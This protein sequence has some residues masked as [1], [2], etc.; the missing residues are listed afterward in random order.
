M[1]PAKFDYHCPA[2]IE[3]VLDLLAKYGDDAKLLAGGQSLVPMMNMRLARPSIIIDINRVAGLDYIKE[4]EDRGLSIGAMTRQRA[5]EC[6]SLVSSLNPLISQV[7]PNIG[8]FQIRNRGTL[9]GSVSHADPSAEIP[10][11]CRILDA[12]FTL[13]SKNGC[14]TVGS[15]EFFITYFT[16][17]LQSTEI[18]TEIRLPQLRSDLGWG[19]E[20]MARRHGDFAMVG[21]IALIEPASNGVCKSV[22]LTMFGV[23][24]VPLKMTEVEDSLS[25]VCLDHKILECVSRQISATLDP[26]SDIHAS[27]EYRK[28]VGGV[29]ARRA[30]MAASRLAFGSTV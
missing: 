10:A 13:R 3:E 26:E 11:V 30:L 19:F 9:G 25:G 18:L 24:G 6:S 14:R 21:A 22:R 4:S 28:D 5:I 23:D 1:K 27:S 8:H 17:A 7:M 12:K 29:L 20:E 16:T 15:E 2:D